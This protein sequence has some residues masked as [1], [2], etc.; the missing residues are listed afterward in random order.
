[1]KNKMDYTLYLCTDRKLMTTDTIEESVELAIKGGCTVVQLREKSC[2]SLEFYQLALRVKKITDH[3]SVPLMINDRVDIAMAV[4][5]AGVHVGKNDLP[6]AVVRQ[7]IGKD[8]VL[9]VSASSLAEAR[10]AQRDGADYL[11]V[12]AMYSTATKTDAELVT[13]DQLKAI[14]RSVK[15]PIVVIG[16][17][18][19][20]TA[21][22]FKGLGIDGLAVVSAVVAQTDITFAAHELVTIFKD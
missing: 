9:G 13:M 18:N 11:G 3:D 14:R 5:A 22:N 4:D 8:K 21:R 1:M 19:Q 2:S 16:G 10:K 6:A 15:I 12:G 7:I 20:N 17:I